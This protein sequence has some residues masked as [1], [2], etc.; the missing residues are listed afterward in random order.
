MIFELITGDYLFRPS[1]KK[2]KNVA[3]DEQHLAQMLATLGP[4]PKKFYRDGKYS[5][6]FFN[7]SGKLQHTEVPEYYPISQILADEYDFSKKAAKEIEDFLMPM[8]NYNPQ[9]RISAQEVLNSPWLNMD[10]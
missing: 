6:D 2:N 5:R 7:K 4:M 9:Y 3:P 10:N 8:L 1:N